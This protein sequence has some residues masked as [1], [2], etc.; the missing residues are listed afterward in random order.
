MI[1]VMVKVPSDLSGAS[2]LGVHNWVK[3]NIAR[4]NPGASPDYKI[5]DSK[6]NRM[7]LSDVAEA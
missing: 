1:Y 3:S 6:G 2:L 5:T 4:S 7:T